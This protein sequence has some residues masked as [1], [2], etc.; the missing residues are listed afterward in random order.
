VTDNATT[1]ECSDYDSGHE[2]AHQRFCAFAMKVV[3]VALLALIASLPVARTVVGLNDTRSFG[4]LATRS[5]G[6][7]QF[8]TYNVP[9]LPP[10]RDQVSYDDCEIESISGGLR[11]RMSWVLFA[12]CAGSRGLTS[13]FFKVESRSGK[14]KTA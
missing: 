5:S 3:I 9:H 2:R 14:H 10:D 6:G 8:A 4:P 7:C 1:N 13:R 12:H 11:E